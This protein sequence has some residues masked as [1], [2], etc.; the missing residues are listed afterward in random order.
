MG[1]KIRRYK[2][3]TNK[4]YENVIHK[5]SQFRI[6]GKKN[7]IENISDEES[8]AENE[9][10]NNISLNPFNHNIFSLSGTEKDKGVVKLYKIPENI[11]LDENNIPLHGV[12]YQIKDSKDIRPIFFIAF[13]SIFVAVTITV[14]VFF[15]CCII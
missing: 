2:L 9:Y 13:C 5:K 14:F 3:I 8:K 4:A 6:L 10:F 15:I 7:K 1:K 11:Y 12:T